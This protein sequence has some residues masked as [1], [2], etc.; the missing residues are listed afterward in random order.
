MKKKVSQLKV[1]LVLF[2][3]RLGI[4]S[5]MMKLVSRFS[6]PVCTWQLQNTTK[7]LPREHKCQA[8]ALQSQY[9]AVIGLDEF[10][11]ALNSIKA[12]YI[13]CDKCLDFCF[14]IRFLF[15]L[16][17]SNTDAPS[18]FSLDVILYMIFLALVDILL[19]QVSY[20]VVA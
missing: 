15:S 4:I 14:I 18:S 9:H 10:G 8:P 19:G 16:I 11:V 13:V 5:H 6:V 3:L 1:F 17:N 12:L 7:H 20:K 2:C